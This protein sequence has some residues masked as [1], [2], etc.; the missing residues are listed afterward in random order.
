MERVSGGAETKYT[1]LRSCVCM[2]LFLL[3]TISSRRSRQF[4]QSQKKTSRSACSIA[5]CVCVGVCCSR[6]RL[7]ARE[8][9]ERGRGREGERRGCPHPNDAGTASSRRET[10]SPFLAKHTACTIRKGR[11]SASNAYSFLKADSDVTYSWE[12]WTEWQKKKK[13]ATDNS[14]MDGEEWRAEDAGEWESLERG[15]E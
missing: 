13:T 3:A 9:Q 2:S 11:P 1:A 15:R 8:R 5:C 10:G 4:Q 6:K 12:L 7:R 14:Q